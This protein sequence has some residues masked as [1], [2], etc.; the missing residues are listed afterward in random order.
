MVN[1]LGVSAY[2]HDSAAALIRAAGVAPVSVECPG[3]EN[4]G[5]FT[6]QSRTCRSGGSGVG[7]AFG[8]LWLVVGLPPS[9]SAGGSGLARVM[10]A[11]QRLVGVFAGPSQPMCHALTRNAVLGR[12]TKNTH[13]LTV[14]SATPSGADCSCQQQQ[15]NEG[16]LSRYLIE[17]V[18]ARLDH[19]L[20]DASL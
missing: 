1:I 12:R 3:W 17:R 18:E 10:S 11:R 16:G 19:L 5:M 4:S 15:I 7:G 14:R 6:H 13:P 20:R 9:P 8:S 2:Y